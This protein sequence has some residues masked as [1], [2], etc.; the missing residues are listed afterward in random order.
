VRRLV[1]WVIALVFFLVIGGAAVW[2]R[3]QDSA[4][5]VAEARAAALEAEV[6]GLQ[7]T[8]TAIVRAQA[9]TAT[10][11]AVATNLPE[12]SLRNALDLVLEA[13]K[14]PSDARLTALQAAFDPPALSVERPEAEHL[15]SGGTHLGGQSSYQILSMQTL[16]QGDDRAEIRTREQWV[17]DELDAQNRRS[18]C[19][20]EETEQTYTLRRAPAGW[21]VADISL[22]GAGRRSDC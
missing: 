18:R 20:R 13:Y 12:V 11:V 6:A 1:P 2:G 5:R 15:I 3:K 4:R 14:E 9:A 19:V 21:L 17:Y 10:A 16:E 22:N 8:V 7:V